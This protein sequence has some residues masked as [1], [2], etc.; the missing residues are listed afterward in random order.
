M[1]VKVMADKCGLR[2]VVEMN[3]DANFG[4]SRISLEGIE[5]MIHL[6]NEWHEHGTVGEVL[7]CKTPEIH[8]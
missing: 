6:I 7:L 3:G 2:V 5:S 1:I 8:E 4:T